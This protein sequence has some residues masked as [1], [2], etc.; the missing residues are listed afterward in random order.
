MNPII[1][2]L[3]R[4]VLSDIIPDK[5][6][7]LTL[8]ENA[9]E[10]FDDLMYWSNKIRVRNFGSCV[11]VCSIV[12]GRLGGCSEDCKFCAQSARYKTDIGPARYTSNEEILHAAEQARNSGI[13]N[14]GIVYSGRT[15]TDDELD[16]VCSLSER[17]SQKNGM[18]LCGSFGILTPSQAVRLASAGLKRYNHN[19]ETSA[20]YFHD[21]VTTHDYSER[22]ETIN[23]ALDAGL[24]VCAGGIFGIGESL[25]DRIE[26][27]ISLRELGV[28]MVP[29]NFLHPIPG[30]PLA[31]SP[32]MSPRQILT[33]IAMFRFMLPHAD[34]KVAGGRVLN[35][36]D[37][38]S[39]IFK[40]GATAIITGN[41]LTTSGRD[42]QQDLKMLS[43]MELVAV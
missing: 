9:R 12:P 23:N 26:M 27:A 30:T 2:Q 5:A 15:I 19:L 29:L 22:V 36:G 10:D 8:V 11:R 28:D 35:L 6:H 31:D 14:F 17:I 4:Q 16:R 43:D 37:M 39:W 38:Q 1:E 21:I 34:I 40:A 32:P 20:D 13:K 24:G 41:Y 7:A 3:A 18:D 42:A 25:S 33:T